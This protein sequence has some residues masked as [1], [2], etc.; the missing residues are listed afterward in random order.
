MLVHSGWFIMY[1]LC[2]VSLALHD[3]I[4]KS[5]MWYPGIS[6]GFMNFSFCHE[7]FIS[8]LKRLFTLPRRNDD[9]TMIWYC[10]PFRLVCAMKKKLKWISTWEMAWFEFH[11][12]SRVTLWLEFNLNFLLG[13]MNIWRGRFCFLL[14][15]CR[16]AYSH[17]MLDS[18]FHFEDMSASK[19]FWIPQHFWASF[20]G[21]TLF[22]SLQFGHNVKYKD[23]GQGTNAKTKAIRSQQQRSVQIWSNALPV[24]YTCSVVCTLCFLDMWHFIVFTLSDV[25]IVQHCR[26]F[27]CIKRIHVVLFVYPFQL[28][29]SL[30]R[31]GK[32]WIFVTSNSRKRKYHKFSF[33]H[34][35]WKV[36][37]GTFFL[38]RVKPNL[39]VY[40][41]FAAKFSW[42]SVSHCAILSIYKPEFCLKTHPNKP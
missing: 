35:Q 39:H 22:V 10:I 18:N 16:I 23:Y 30:F 33:G 42:C 38:S 11:C 19:F 40:E 26:T 28:F 25:A 34:S 4:S 17:P 12:L 32:Q 37:K 8:E 24:T 1:V 2:L 6:V 29:S 3:S 41:T 27:A 15:L 36:T 5:A 20:F 9:A 31:H 21:Y 7:I 13:E 14:H